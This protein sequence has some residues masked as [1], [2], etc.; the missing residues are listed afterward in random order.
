MVCVNARTGQP[1]WRF[2]MSHGGV[3]AGVVL[4]EDLVIAVHGKENID[5][6][7][8]GRMVGIRKPDR[9]PGVEDP[10]LELD[11]ESEVWRNEEIE[12]FTSSPVLYRDRVYISVKTG[13]LFCNDAQ[14]A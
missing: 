6:S 13:E 2:K 8:I 7:R 5:S 11:K 12:S 10:I 14:T 4:H 9:L 3:N 1:L